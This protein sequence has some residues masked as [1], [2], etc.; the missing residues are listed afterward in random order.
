MI[1]CRNLAK[2]YGKL[3][4]VSDFSLHLEEHE[5]LSILGPSGCGKSTLLRLIAGLEVPSQGQVLLQNR[6]IS[7]EK[8]I[9]PPQYSGDPRPG[10]MLRMLPH[11]AAARIICVVPAFSGR[12]SNRLA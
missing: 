9:L 3:E 4:A 2:S 11:L 8:I 12:R 10:R 7:G 6:E 1:E 5:F